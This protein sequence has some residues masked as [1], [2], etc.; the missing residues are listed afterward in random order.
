MADD[1]RTKVTNLGDGLERVDHTVD[2]PNIFGEVEY[3]YSTYVQIIATA[4][5]VRLAFGDRRPPIGKVKPLLGVILPHEVAK[6]LVEIVAK[7]GPAIEK[8]KETLDA[9]AEPPPDVG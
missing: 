5:D 3:F 9:P 6:H 7:I 1:S 8:A 2:N 4:T